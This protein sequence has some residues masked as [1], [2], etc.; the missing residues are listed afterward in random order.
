[1]YSGFGFDKDKDYEKEKFSILNSNRAMGSC[2]I[3][4][5]EYSDLNFN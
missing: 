4:R 5:S 2:K 3:K 1:M